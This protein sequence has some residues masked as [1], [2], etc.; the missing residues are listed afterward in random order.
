MGKGL[1][2]Q[3]VALGK[4]DIRMQKRNLDPFLVLYAKTSSKGIKDFNVRPKT[5]RFLKENLMILHGIELDNNFL[6]VIPK[7]VF[8]I[9]LWP[10]VV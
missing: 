7:A 5:V 10:L 2:T 8:S 1:S 3:Q 9:I 6:L 4:L